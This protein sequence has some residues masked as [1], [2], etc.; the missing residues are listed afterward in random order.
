MS[1]DSATPSAGRS[2][3]RASADPT[4]LPDSGILVHNDIRVNYTDDSGREH[5]IPQ[6][7]P[8]H[9]NVGDDVISPD[10]IEMRPYGSTHHMRTIT[11]FEESARSSSDVEGTFTIQRHSVEE[12]DQKERQR[13]AAFV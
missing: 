7:W 5:P 1:G 9:H 3:N 12:P 4:N 13:A 8:L 6:N 2:A 11:E 10:A